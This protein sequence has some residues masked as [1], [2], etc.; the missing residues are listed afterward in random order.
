MS[1]KAT[2]IEISDFSELF[3]AAIKRDVVDHITERLV[4]DF[5]K[6]ARKEVEEAVSTIGLIRSKEYTPHTL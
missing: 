4:E 5:R 2:N 1:I 3:E 6:E